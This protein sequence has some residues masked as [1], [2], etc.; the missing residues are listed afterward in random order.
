MVYPVAKHGYW[1]SALNPKLYKE[2]TGAP[3]GCP[4]SHAAAEPQTSASADSTN[5][6]DGL[7]NEQSCHYT[8]NSGDSWHDEHGKM[9]TTWDKPYYGPAWEPGGV[10]ATT[11]TAPTGLAPKSARTNQGG[12]DD[13]GDGWRPSWGWI[14]NQKGPKPVTP[15]RCFLDTWRRLPHNLQAEI[16][17]LDAG[18]RYPSP[19]CDASTSIKLDADPRNAI[20]NPTPDQFDGARLISLLTALSLLIVAFCSDRTALTD[21]MINGIAQATAI[22]SLEVSAARAI[23]AMA[24]CNAAPNASP[25]LR[26]SGAGRTAGRSLSAVKASIT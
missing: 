1:I 7:C 12:E 3:M 14:D 16:C 18:E 24:V 2:C 4:G 21:C 17:P 23:E 22:L 19:E 15:A 5:N 11:D 6:L 10:W 9:H 13:H 8:D 25:T 26:R 20:A